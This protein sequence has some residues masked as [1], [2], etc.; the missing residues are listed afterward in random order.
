MLYF[1]AQ[2]LDMK[3]RYC[4]TS[5]GIY[6]EILKQQKKEHRFVVSKQALNK[7]KLFSEKYRSCG[8]YINTR[9]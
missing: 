8:N 1:D 5:K 9:N 7:Q 4:K 6:L 3:R 2:V